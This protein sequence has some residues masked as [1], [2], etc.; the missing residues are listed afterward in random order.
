MSTLAVENASVD[1]G[2]TTAV[3]DVSLAV[4]SG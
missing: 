3:N 4:N 1:Y 2:S